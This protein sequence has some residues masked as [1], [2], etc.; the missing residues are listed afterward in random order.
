[1]GGPHY[2]RIPARLDV[3]SRPRGRVHNCK[4]WGAGI[5]DNRV[6]KT[7]EI[8]Y[9]L[10]VHFAADEEVRTAVLHARQDIKLVAF[11]L[12]GIAIMLGVIADR[13]H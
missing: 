6:R 2:E 1:M 11:L 10:F 13:V 7:T 4:P 9:R 12:M 3:G 5:D 8:S